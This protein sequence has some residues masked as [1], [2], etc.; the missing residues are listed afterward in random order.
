MN[1]PIILTEFGS[2]DKIAIFSDDISYISRK[3]HENGLGVVFSPYTEICIIKDS[4][5][6]TFRVN[7]YVEDIVEMM[8]E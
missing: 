4:I 2:N 5:V 1:R 6:K 7:E 8:N 3:S